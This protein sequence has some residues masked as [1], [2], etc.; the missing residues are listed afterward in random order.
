MPTKRGFGTTLIE[1]SAK[2]EGGVAELVFEPEGIAWRFGYHILAHP[3][4]NA[5][6]QNWR[7]RRRS[8]ANLPQ[9]TPPSS[10]RGFVF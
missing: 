4:K 6:R 7:P 1:Q 9:W 2:S 5:F 10:F 8:K 3:K